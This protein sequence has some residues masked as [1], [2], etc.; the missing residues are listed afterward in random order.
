MRNEERVT[1]APGTNS[2]VTTRKSLAV[3]PEVN[4]ACGPG[5][6]RE[7]AAELFLVPAS[8]PLSQFL[9]LDP[10]QTLQSSLVSSQVFNIFQQLLF[11]HR[12]SPVLGKVSQKI[13]NFL[14]FPDAL[15]LREKPWRDRSSSGL[16]PSTE[17][18]V[19]QV[20]LPVS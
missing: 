20:S 9:S 17:G 12:S 4:V 11:A 7:S 5:L 18:A 19:F 10:W 16:R 13:A 3:F 2:G 14:M 1:N 8:R 15:V 6:A